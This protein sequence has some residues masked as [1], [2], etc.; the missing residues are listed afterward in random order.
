MLTGCAVDKTLP[1]GLDL[2]RTSDNGSCEITGT[3]DAATAE[4]TYRVTATNATGADA[5]PATVSITVEAEQAEGNVDS[6]GDGLIEINTLAELNN[7]RYSLDGAGYKTSASDTPN[8]NGCPNNV[9]RGYELTADLDFDADGDG[10]TWT[11]NSDGSVTLDASDDNDTYFDIAS[12]GS[13]GGWVPIGDCGP[14]GI[15]FN[16]SST[17][18]DDTADDA[19]FTAVFEGN[20]HTITGLATVRDLEYIGLFGAIGTGA[21]IR[22]LGLVGNLAR[23]AGTSR[24]Y[25]GGLVGR[26]GDGSITASYATGDADG[27]AGDE[28][29][30]GGL[31]GYQSRGP[32]TASHTPLETR[33]VALA[34]RTMSVAWSVFPVAQSPT[35]TPPGTLTAVLA[36]TTGSADWSASRRIAPSPLPTP[37]AALTAARELK[38]MSAAWSAGSSEAPSPPHTPVDIPAVAMMAVATMSV[39]WSVCNRATAPSPLP[40]PM[41]MLTGARAAT[42]SAS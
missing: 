6:D 30:V 18:E 13:S 4:A 42:G 26:Q 39:A 31:V 33:T 27:G 24:A 19:P 14:N 7:V 15:C 9:C 10:S 35:P 34:T 21:D 28:D 40:T 12:D 32:I 5:T 37:L 22:N 38:T 41:G 2:D 20:D 36:T 16:I 17:P 23:K 8:T 25:I 11:R 1:T 3:P 29:Y